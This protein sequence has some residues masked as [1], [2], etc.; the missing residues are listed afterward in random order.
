MLP[1]GSRRSKIRP[2]RRSLVG[3][4]IGNKSDPDAREIDFDQTWSVLEGAI[5][6]IQH[7]NVSN[8]SYEQ[9]YRKAYQLVLAKRGAK[10]YDNVSNLIADHLALRRQLLM[11]THFS[12]SSDADYVK[13]ILSEWTHHL[14]AMKFVSDV[15]MYL[16]RV[17]VKDTKRLLTYDLGIQIFKDAFIKKNNAEIGKRLIEIIIDEITKIRRGEVIVTTMPISKAISMLE[18]LIENNIND[19]I[20]GENFYQCEFEPTFLA[21]SESFYS[22]LALS[23]TNHSLGIQYIR[24][25]TAF[26]KAE[27]TRLHNYLPIATMPKVI[28]LMDNILIKDKIDDVMSL[29][30]ENQG[31]SYLLL[32][33]IVS[34]TEN[35]KDVVLSQEVNMLYALVSRVEE[36]LG[37]LKSRLRSVMLEQG[38]GI[39]L[40][41]KESQK[42]AKLKQNGELAV[43]KPAADSASIAVS[44]IDGVLN[45]H[46]HAMMLLEQSFG[47]NPNIG[48]AITLAIRDFVNGPAKKSD[49]GPGPAESLSIYMDHHIKNFNKLAT[50]N[51]A[52]LSSFDHLDDLIEKSITFLRYIKDKD[53]FE[54]NYANHF[55]KRFLNSKGNNNVAST[56]SRLGVDLEELIISKLSEEMGS[57]ALDK[58]LRMNKDIKLSTSVTQEWKNYSSRKSVEHFLNMELKICNVT[59]WPKSMTKD[60][61]SFTSNAGDAS[62]PP[63]GFA[64]PRQLKPSMRGFEEFW[65][66][67]KKNQNKSLFWSPKFGSMDF[68]ITYPSKTYEINMSTYAGMIMLLFAPQEGLDGESMLA[69]D[70][71]K[72]LTYTEI[73]ELTGIPDSDLKR[74]LQSIAVA[75]RLRLLT[76]APMTKDVKP[77]DTFRLNEKFTSPSIKVK[78][79]TVSAS[80]SKSEKS[81][82]V[83]T[84]HEQEVEEVNSNVTEGRKLEVNAAVVRI[85]KSRQIFKHNELV[86]ELVKQL[87]NRFQPLMSLIKQRIEDLIEKEY[88]E[89]DSTDRNVYRYIA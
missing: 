9:L 71:K 24:D 26:I 84:E 62:S 89:R 10:L 63:N 85:M 65:L 18:L 30:Y 86:E 1:A 82:K 37:L 22:Q 25:C 6:L 35:K 70:E 45:Y 12:S 80:T 34:A 51:I 69:F 47:L 27:E 53:A 74:Q 5:M 11:E 3:G 58:I 39:L 7:Q 38:N 31:L 2:P 60:Y 79:L 78:V 19:G 32:P 64:W 67:E 36:N 29:P 43:K 77:T 88:I 13:Q 40:R 56:S 73:S 55:A 87:L 20:S 57:S 81:G 21:R 52:Q 28:S 8:L 72:S 48:Q 59:D 14:Q 54:A 61:K 42:E 46:H 41:V 16:N 4:A 17:F 33:L 23:L 44:W 75:P 15:L 50:K 83:K 76:K 49:N 66:S 68:R